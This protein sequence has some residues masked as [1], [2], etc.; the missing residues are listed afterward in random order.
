MNDVVQLTSFEHAWSTNIS[1][2]QW[3]AHPARVMAMLTRSEAFAHAKRWSF[4]PR[5]S[6]CSSLLSDVNRH[7][8]CLDQSRTIAIEMISIQSGKR[9]EEEVGSCQQ[10]E[11][12]TRW[13]EGEWYEMK[14]LEGFKEL[15]KPARKVPR[16]FKAVNPFNSPMENQRAKR[17]QWALATCDR[18]SNPLGSGDFHRL[19]RYWI[20]DLFSQRPRSVLTT[21]DA[22]LRFVSSC[23]LSLWQR[24]LRANMRFYP[25][26]ARTVPSSGTFRLSCVLGQPPSRFARMESSRGASQAFLRA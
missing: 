6:F 21:Y 23:H 9:L 24:G 3:I 13:T 14:F 15:E 1:S 7:N 16:V 22:E 11:P 10:P 2:S 17:G 12:I 5:R 25:C 8:S 4:Q 19:V 20:S 18:K 26:R